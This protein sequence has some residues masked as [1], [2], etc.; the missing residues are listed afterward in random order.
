MFFAISIA[1]FKG[2]ILNL[3]HITKV[4][5]RSRGVAK[6]N[7]HVYITLRSLEQLLLWY[8]EKKNYKEC[9]TKNKIIEWQRVYISIYQ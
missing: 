7:G 5:S 3:Y 6:W 1:P 2:H 8:G 9:F 4:G